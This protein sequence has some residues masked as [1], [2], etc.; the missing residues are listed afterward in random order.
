MY[1][2]AGKP[3]GRGPF[4]RHTHRLKD[5]I[6]M[7]LEAL[8]CGGMECVRFRVGEIGGLL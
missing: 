2:G 1:T 5:N 7:D 8:E 3:E 6:K 4:G